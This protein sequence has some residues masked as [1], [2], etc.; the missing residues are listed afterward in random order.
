MKTKFINAFIKSMIEY[1]D[2]M[3]LR[4]ESG[5]LNM[6][7]PVNILTKNL[8]GSNI[9]LELLDG[10]K[11]ASEEITARL[12]ANRNM[13]SNLKARG[14]YYFF[15]IFIFD[16]SPSED[17]KDAFIASQVQKIMGKKY[18]KCI[19]VDLSTGTVNKYF[20]TPLSDF[21]I[22]KT[23][24]DILT[25]GVPEEMEQAE[26]YDIVNRKQ[27][28]YKIEFKVKTPVITYT[29]IGINIIVGALIYLYSTTSGISYSQLLLDFGAKVNFNILTGEYWRFVTPVFLHANMV[30]LLVNCY[31]LYV[32]GVSV[33][34]IFGRFRFIT[35]YFIAGILGNILSFMFSPNNGVGASGA[36]FGLLG[37]LLYFGLEKPTLFRVYFGRNIMMTLVINLAYGFSNKGID[38]FAHIGGLIG[39]FLASGIVAKTEKKRWYFNRYLYYILTIFIALSGIAY[40]FNSKQNKIIIKIN[41][42]EMFQSAQEQDWNKVEAKAEEILELKPDNTDINIS[43]LWS[44]T[45]AEAMNQKYDEALEHA[46]GL[47]TIDPPN[48]HYLLGILYYDMGQFDLSEEEL[49][50]A[51]KAGASN[52]QIDQIL[53]D[54]EAMKGE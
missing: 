33:E 28:E 29:L 35:V 46:K 19:S 38:N 41:E 14:A 3:P 34:K 11:L 47:T 9:I 5:N 27:K 53:S 52:E 6:D 21:G 50:E 25:K 13:L 45:V 23:A 12:E 2:F 36:I 1:K 18:L 7:R 4:D 49:L 39:G 51:K 26:I 40:G 31:S 44:L 17:K 16:T 24:I 20:K 30:H 32:I 10:D 54:I 15:A 48:G 43:V 8:S 42:L 22:T 37:T